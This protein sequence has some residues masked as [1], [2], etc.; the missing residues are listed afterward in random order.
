M[1]LRARLLTIMLVVVTAG[2]AVAGW[3][4]YVSL[5]SFLVDRVDQQL[6]TA[7]GPALRALTDPRPRNGYLPPNLPPNT[8]ALLKGPDGKVLTALVPTGGQLPASTA[9][10]PYFEANVPGQGAYRFAVAP[11]GPI[12]GPGPET[13][14]TQATLVVGVPLKDVQDT[15]SR[16][17]W[18]ELAV[19]GGV[20]AA[21]ALLALWLVRL[22]LR[23]LTRI[24]DTAGAIAAGDLSRRVED[25]SPRTE[26]GRLGRALNAML[27]RIEAAFAERQ[28]AE[29]RLRQFLA[30][31]SH[32]LQT[33][34]TSVRGYAELF[35]RGAA[36]RPADL[37]NAMQR[38]ESEATRMSLLVDDMLLLARLDQG[39]PMEREPVDLAAVA[40]DQVADARA[41]EPGRPID[42]ETEDEVL[43][44]G[45]EMRLR[46]VV[47]N[48]LGNARVHTPPLTPVT[49]RARADGAEAVLEV[50]DHGP[51]IPPEHL[52]RIFERFFRADPSRARASGGN[53][54]GLSIVS[55]IV[56]AHDG[57][58][59]VE[60]QPGHGA[61]FRLVLPRSGPAGP[62]PDPPAAHPAASAPARPAQS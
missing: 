55:A 32:E 6:Q 62:G 47:A 30:D 31:A 11:V 50:T 34:L 45:D 16:L 29:A 5:R 56:S 28:A 58:V 21:M 23:P 49:V 10:G 52:E 36:E 57:R 22:G 8:V 44:V 25:E 41:V 24:E 35:R 33:P 26:V 60:S 7:V 4:T 61:T 39:R 53:G 43:V 9:A 48:L 20:L 27:G 38:I 46:Q 12:P 42:L 37:A 13:A 14:L 15:L 1:S 40:R 59:E 2:L 54:L 17:V 19:G 18:I 51:G 3:A